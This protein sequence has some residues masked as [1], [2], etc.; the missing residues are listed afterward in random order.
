[1]DFVGELADGPADAVAVGLRAAMTDVLETNDYIDIDDMDAAITAACLVA[2][3]IDPTVLVDPNG[4]RYLDQM[5]FAAD[6]G[7]RELAAR[8]FVRAFEPKNNEWYELWAEPGEFPDLSEA[9]LAPFLAVV[10]ATQQVPT[11]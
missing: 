6:D 9:A 1:L 4:R 8:V 10:R 3:R 2:A 11:T 7:L 5:N